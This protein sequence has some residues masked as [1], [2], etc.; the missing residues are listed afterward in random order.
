MDFSEVE[1]PDGTFSL[2]TTIQQKYSENE[3]VQ[4]N[5][6]PV[7]V[8]SVSNSVAPTD[9]LEFDASFNFLGNQG[10]A[11]SQDYVSFD[12]L[13]VCYSKKLTAAN[14]VLTDISSGEGCGGATHH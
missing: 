12:S 6:F 10:Q 8:R 14:N 7:Y 11:S 4:L 2:P 13:G 5:G 9:T 1:N 3:T